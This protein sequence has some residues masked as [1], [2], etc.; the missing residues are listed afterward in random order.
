MSRYKNV[1]K[2]NLFSLFNLYIFDMLVTA[3]T[4][5][6]ETFSEI[7]SCLKIIWTPVAN[8]ENAY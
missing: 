8:R 6:P 3:L 2:W 1:H 4:D 7:I 5:E